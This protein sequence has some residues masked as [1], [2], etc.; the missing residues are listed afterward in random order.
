MHRTLNPRNRVRVPGGVR[1][2]ESRNWQTRRLQVPHGAGSN[3]ASPTSSLKRCPFVQPAGQRA[4][5][6]LIVVRIHGGQRRRRARLRLRF[7]TADGPGRHRVAAHLCSYSN[8]GRE[9]C[10]RCWMLR[11][12]IP[13]SARSPSHSSCLLSDSGKHASPPALAAG[14]RL[15]EQAR[16]VSTCGCSSA[17]SERLHAT[18]RVTSSNLVSRSHAALAQLAVG[19]GLRTLTV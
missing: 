17:W 2:G 13:P 10:P 9:A 8:H 15:P 6:A 14:V 16:L 18:E 3:P 19:A 12:R 4:L 1:M 7:R 5:D 11:V